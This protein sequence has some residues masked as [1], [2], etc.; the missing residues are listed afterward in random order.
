MEIFDLPQKERMEK[1][2]MEI[3]QKEQQ[4][5]KFVGSYRRMPGQTLFV[6]NRKTKEIKPAPLVGSKDVD[7]K[8]QEA[9]SRPK[10]VVEAGCVYLWALNMKNCIKKL[11]K[12]GIEV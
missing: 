1:E 5:F 9:T 7:F 2:E 6:Y 10:L 11:R 8:T 3:L 4:E 12:E